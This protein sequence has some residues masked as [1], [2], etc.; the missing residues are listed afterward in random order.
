MNKTSAAIDASGLKEIKIEYSKGKKKKIILI[1]SLSVALFIASIVAI[2]LG[3]SSVNFNTVLQ[4][5][6]DY[7]Y[8]MML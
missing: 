4:V 3:A 6:G 7:L 5:F 1:I 8:I 2:T